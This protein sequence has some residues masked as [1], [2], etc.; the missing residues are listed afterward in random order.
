M[1][2]RVTPQLASYLNSLVLLLVCSGCTV[3][4][5]YIQKESQVSQF[6]KNPANSQLNLNQKG[7]STPK[8][9]L[10][11]AA[12][13]VNEIAERVTVRIDAR[14]GNGSGVIVAHEGNT[15]W[16]LTADH[17]VNKKGNY[18]VVTPDNKQHSINYE[19]IK[20]PK[21]IDLA[22]LK[23]SSPKTYTVATLGN[24]Y[25]KGFEERPLVFLSGFPIANPEQRNFTA[26]NT[27]PQ[28]TAF[29]QV[30]KL[31][32]LGNGSG[33]VYTNFSQQGMSGGPVF[34]SYGRVIGIHTRS[35]AQ[36]L[37]KNGKEIRVN[38]GYSL[39][40]PITSFLGV[41][42][43]I[44]IQMQSLKVKKSALPRFRES[45]IEAIME[46]LFTAQTPSEGA[47][48]FEW[49]N[50]GNRLWRIGKYS[51]AVN[52]FE[53][54]IELRPKLAQAYYAKGKV[55]ELE[56]IDLEFEEQDDQDDRG[57]KKTFQQA[58]VAFE[59]AAE[60]NPNLYEAWRDRAGV[61]SELERS[62]EALTSINKAIEKNSKNFSL[63]YEK[64][65]I[66]AY[67]LNHHEEAEEAYSKSI[68][69]NPSAW[70]FLYR[71]ANRMRMRD[72]KARSLIST[73]RLTSS[74]TLH[75][76]MKVACKL[77]FSMEMKKEH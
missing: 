10:K 69:L 46:S 36:A 73:E 39:G 6:E 29:H 63:Y 50:Y 32:S 58:A 70:T 53:Q 76:L 27:F 44:S 68:A 56:G 12:K 45:D 31:T 20:S 74:P 11:L 43:K 71:G 2:H 77:T 24:Y 49:L 21:G 48:A 26:G 22:L 25:V 60:L 7:S 4:E 61:L 16:V 5:P 1:N 52:A 54:A 59:K 33:L 55:L 13:Q 18:Q 64:G 23:F 67:S 3:L 75:L 30:K 42:S 66:L 62:Q 40:V 37:S 65:Y 47:T 72:Y 17:V 28:V 19:T 9:E 14:K 35:E 34:D 38:L 15:Y 57:A 8:V 51:K 41:A